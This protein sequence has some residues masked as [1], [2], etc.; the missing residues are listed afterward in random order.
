MHPYSYPQP[1][2]PQKRRGG[3]ALAML[4]VTLFAV[5]ACTAGIATVADKTPSGQ[6]VGT[7]TTVDAEPAAEEPTPA[8]VTLKPSDLKLKVTLLDKE[9]FGSAGCNITYRVVPT[10]VGTMPD[11]DRE[12]EVI[13][14]VRGGEDG[15]QIGRFTM[16]GDQAQVTEEFISTPSSLSKLT[17]K[18]TEIS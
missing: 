5:V 10:I 17:A 15:P 7:G 9:C 6:S 2:A 12:Y 8:T 16:Q 11:P 13:Y 18:V 1:S 3:V 4:G 14:E